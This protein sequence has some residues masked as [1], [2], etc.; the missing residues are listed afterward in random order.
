MKTINTAPGAY[1]V[2]FFSM[3]AIEPDKETRR[4]PLDFHQENE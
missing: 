2:K 3:Y 1:L 4:A